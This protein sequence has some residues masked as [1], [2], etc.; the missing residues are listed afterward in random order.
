MDSTKHIVAFSAALALGLA[1]GPGWAT[2]GPIVH[3]TTYGVEVDAVDA[4]G[5]PL[6]GGTMEVRFAYGGCCRQD[7]ID[8]QAGHLSADV[9]SPWAAGRFEPVSFPP[10]DSP[11][12][13]VGGIGHCSAFTRMWDEMEMTDGQFLY[14]H[15]AALPDNLGPWSFNR[16]GRYDLKPGDTSEFRFRLNTDLGPLTGE[17]RVLWVAN[18]VPEPATWG[19]MV[20]G[21]GMM[22]ASLRRRKAWA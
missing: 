18:R 14:A 22:G 21:F 6:G 10:E 7:I 16:Y 15:V 12:P 3:T 17:G 20:A 11:R 8:L 4:D 5:N 1:A 9:W 2:D 19:L 13:C